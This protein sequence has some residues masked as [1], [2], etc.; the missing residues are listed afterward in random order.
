MISQDSFP[1]KQIKSR[2]KQLKEPSKH[3]SIL[4]PICLYSSL[5]SSLYFFFHFANFFVSSL[6]H[7]FIII[8]IFRCFCL[9][10]FCG[11]L[12]IACDTCSVCIYWNVTF[13][14]IFLYLRYLLY[15]F[16]CILIFWGEDS[17]YA[18]LAS[19]LNLL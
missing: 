1:E 4:S 17:R 16:I 9:T 10:C 7:F 8:I 13:F 6:Y 15:V 11:L 3:L 2:S 12:S 18:F 14:F 19:S 5:F